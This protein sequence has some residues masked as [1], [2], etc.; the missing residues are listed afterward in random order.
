MNRRIKWLPIAGCLLLCALAVILRMR[1]YTF[2]V[3]ENGR[4]MAKTCH[5]G[6]KIAGEALVYTASGGVKRYAEGFRVTEPLNGVILDPPKLTNMDVFAQA[7]AWLAAGERVMILYL[8]GF[9]WESF[10]YAQEQGLIPN[11]SALPA[12]RAAALYPTITPVNYAAMVTGRA[13]GENGVTARGAHDIRCDTIFDRAAAQGKRAF[14]AEGDAQILRF[15]VP[16]ELNLD[17][18]EDGDTDSEVIAC[19]MAHMQDCDLML[20]HLHGIDDKGHAY[21]PRAQE[22]LD[23]IAQTDWWYAQLAAAWPGRIIVAADHGQHENDGNGDA[24]YA[25]KRGVHGAFAPSDL[26]VPFLIK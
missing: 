15:S 8:D 16:Q 21:G 20:V 12:Q 7:D 10:G 22:T 1:T 14:I 6:D 9:G 23:K 19:A 24:Y 3:V 4:Y 5:F 18:D 26:Y 17:M 2:T 25:D 13:P 11:L